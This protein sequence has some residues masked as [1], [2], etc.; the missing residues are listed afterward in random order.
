M[1]EH[2]SVSVYLTGVSRSL[3][4]ELIRHRHLSYSQLS[5]RYVPE[6]DAGMVEPAVIA[7]DP[8]LPATFPTR[9]C[10]ASRPGRRPAACCPTRPRRGSW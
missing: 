6:R 8:E 3:T 9:P 2:G 7:E 4:H 10:V 1:L 5:Q